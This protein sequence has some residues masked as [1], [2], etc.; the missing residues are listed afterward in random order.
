VRVLW[1]YCD[2]LSLFGDWFCQL[3]AESLGK[4]GPRGQPI[5]QTPVRAIGSTDQH[6]LLQRAMEGPADQAL[7]FVTVGGP[8]PALRVP[9][10][11][12]L[13]PEMREFGGREVFEVFEALRIGCM[14]GLIEAGRPLVHLHVPRLDERALGALFAHFE[15]ET[16]LVGYLLGIDPFN[17]PGVEAGKRFA[18]GLLGRA[19][20]EADRDRALSLLKTGGKPS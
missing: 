12:G 19:G 13:D 7:T 9:D 4:T 6:S 16:A 2:R 15:V 1:T 18:H 17:Q 5:G 3:W 8:W 10:A 14:A 20:F 11:R